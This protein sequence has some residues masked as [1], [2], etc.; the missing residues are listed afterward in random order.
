MS[1]N[2]KIEDKKGKR[3]QVFSNV[4][5]FDAPYYVKMF[6]FGHRVDEDC[7]IAIGKIYC[8]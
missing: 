4:H 1:D 2:L 3:E 7:Y 6:D 5:V 8:L